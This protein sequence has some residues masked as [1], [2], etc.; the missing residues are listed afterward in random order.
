MAASK[1]TET[2]AVSAFTRNFGG[3]KP[4]AQKGV[5]PVSSRGKIA[6]YCIPANA[7]EASSGYRHHPATSRLQ[8][9]RGRSQDL[10]RVRV[11]RLRRPL[12][13]AGITPDDGDGSSQ[14]PTT[15]LLRSRS[16][17]TEQIIHQRRARIAARERFG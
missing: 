2:V 6:G 10:Q 13:S 16:G 8:S 4:N 17:V 14:R 7:Y 1:A 5:V 9:S 15:A 3:Y 12:C 11:H